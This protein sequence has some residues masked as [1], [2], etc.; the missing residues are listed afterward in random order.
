MR[1]AVNYGSR[2]RIIQSRLIFLMR[3]A[4]NYGSRQRIN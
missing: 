1:Q 2:Q 3:Q 4:V